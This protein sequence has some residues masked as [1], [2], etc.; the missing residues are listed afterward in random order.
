MYF[1]YAAAFIEDPLR[2]SPFKLPVSPGLHELVSA[3]FDYVPGLIADSIP[4]GWGRMVQDRAF[5]KHGLPAGRVRV[6]DRLS[7]LGA[8]GMGALVFS[9]VKPLEADN[10]SMDAWPLDL[11]ALAAQATRVYDGSAEDLLP[12]MRL[13]GGSPGGA[14][15]KMLAGLRISG[16][17]TD[18]IA[19][20]TPA[21]VTGRLPALPADYVPCLIK[22]GTSQ[23]ARLYG[24]DVGAVEEG[25]ARM[26][27]LAGL[28][29][30]T[31]HLLTAR[32]GHRHFAT[33]RFDRHGPGGAGRFHMHTLGGLLHAS[34][35]APTLDYE[36]LLAATFA[37]TQDRAQ[38][39]EAF[40]R[41]AFNVFAFNRD[42]HARN[43]SFLMGES[44]AWR[45][46]P[47]YDLTYN[48]G[49]NGYHSTSVAGESL[50]PTAEH[51]RTVA[52]ARDLSATDTTEVVDQVVDAVGQWEAIAGELEIAPI[53]I[54]RLAT[55]FTRTR[56]EAFP[57][58]TTRV[59]PARTRR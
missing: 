10:T 47:A 22:F 4:D 27:R 21:T 52:T 17:K 29:I 16:Q 14:R 42:D 56:A 57:P 18:L 33:E 6:I 32:D 19:G 41:A 35:R 1:E 26:A 59:K 55:V 58:S 28:D 40:R 3:D 9:P 31:T 37:L 50:N 2:V 39:K 7:A 30:P 49:I 13:A 11:E 36:S 48:T 44:G 38:L 15:P 53:V 51:L 8:A 54:S 25:Y 24:R 20:V 5:E 34:H 46:A 12:E 43:V 23:D 45:L